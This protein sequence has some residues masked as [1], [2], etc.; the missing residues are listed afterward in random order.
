MTHSTLVTVSLDELL[1][2][3]RQLIREEIADKQDELITRTQVA[4]LLGVTLRTVDNWDHSGKIKRVG[5]AGS[6]PVYWK[7]QVLLCGR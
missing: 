2:A 1:G 6:R 3:I 5:P 4:T 7:K